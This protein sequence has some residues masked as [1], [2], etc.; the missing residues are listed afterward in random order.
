[1]LEYNTKETIVKR[2]FMLPL[3]ENWK[4]LKNGVRSFDGAHKSD[5]LV[6]Y[7]GSSAV[8]SG[9]RALGWNIWDPQIFFP[10]FSGFPEILFYAESIARNLVNLMYS[11]SATDVTEVIRSAVGCRS[12][13]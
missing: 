2:G 12:L 11:F 8:T 7:V 10:E 13:A 4:H 5:R 9:C 6:Q 1:M 3:R